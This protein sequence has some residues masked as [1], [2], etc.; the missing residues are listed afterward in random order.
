[1]GALLQPGDLFIDVGAHIGYFS[2]LAASLVGKTGQVFSFEPIA[3]NRKY[4]EH[5]IEI[6]YLENVR[7]IP[8]V[9][10]NR[11]G[12][13]DFFFNIDNDGGHA[14]WD[15][16]KHPFNKKSKINRISEASKL[17]ALTVFSY[18]QSFLVSE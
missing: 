8:Q 9:V 7:I 4:L 10:S 5:N 16:S 1:M 14:L 6:N 13:T 15:I 11:T 12:V 2:V 18:L 3:E 17:Q